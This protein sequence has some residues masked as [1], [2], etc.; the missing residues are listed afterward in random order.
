M[1]KIRNARTAVPYTEIRDATIV[2]SDGLSARVLLFFSNRTIV[3]FQNR[4]F[5][6][7]FFGTRSA[8]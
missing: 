6:R 3:S 8:V 7:D 1:L 5:G 2:R 4:I